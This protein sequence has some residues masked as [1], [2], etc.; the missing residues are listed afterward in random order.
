MKRLVRIA[1]KHDD[2]KS[3]NKL[4]AQCIVGLIQG[5]PAILF[6]NTAAFVTLSN[7]CVV[8]LL[9]HRVNFACLCESIAARNNMAEALV[10]FQ[11]SDIKGALLPEKVVGKN[12]TDA[13][14]RWIKCRGLTST[15]SDNHSTLVRR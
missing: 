6:K 1:L 11:E 13:L 12:T 15:N 4:L 2:V 10:I 3:V 9:C 7:L 5:S 8:T 14:R